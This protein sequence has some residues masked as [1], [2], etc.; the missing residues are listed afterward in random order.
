MALAPHDF[1]CLR[2]DGV[3]RDFGSF[4]AL[5]DVT[6]DVARG[7]FIALLGPSGC[8]KSTALNCLAGL[9]TLTSGSIWLDDIRVDRLKPE[10]RGFG[11]VFQNYALFP[12]MSV[13]R[14]V[15]FGLAMQ[16]R[17]RAEIAKRVEAALALVRLTAQAEKLPGQLSGG[18][19][20][21]VAIARATVIEPPLVLMDEPLSNLDAKL[22][23][24]MRA[25]IRRI[26]DLVG[27]TTIYVTH[28]QDEALSLADRVVVL[29]E[30][31]VRQIGTPEEL[32]ARPSHADVAEFMGYRNMVPSRATPA[33]DGAAEVAIGEARLLGTP[34]EAYEGPVLI[35]FRPDD[36][37]P[38][39]AGP[40]SAKV[41]AAEYRGRDF[42][43]KAA[44]PSGAELYFRSEQKVAPGEAIRLGVDPAR[45]LIYAADA[46]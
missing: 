31:R 32:Y 45:V 43:G 24:E 7:E 6:L 3:S 25:E 27:S 17:P 20:Q 34:V 1:R 10:E 15:G 22:R 42:F 4:N 2:L 13:R 23:L 35:A 33:G 18:Q 14:N 8:G 28:D 12:H 30:G 11:M 19:Q 36:L 40:I 37:T 44:T 41:T 21:R 16:G 29:R 26:H 5:K 46:A 38:R 9:L 39:E